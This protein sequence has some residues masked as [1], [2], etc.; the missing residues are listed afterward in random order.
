MVTFA[1]NLM[2]GSDAGC[3]DQNKK[4]DRRNIFFDLLLF[5]R[6]AAIRVMRAAG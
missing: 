2:D 6:A 4:M 5:F 3:L 1:R